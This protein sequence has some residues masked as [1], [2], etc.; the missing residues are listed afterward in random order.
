MPS[1][2]KSQQRLMGAAEHGAT[3][4]MAKKLR[5]SMSH[6]QLHDFAVG[7][8]K[9]KPE[10]THMSKDK[11]HHSPI[12]H[13]HV[14]HHSDGTKTVHHYHH[15]VSVPE[16]SA[17]M[18]DHSHAVAD[19]KGMQDNFASQMGASNEG[20]MPAATGAVPAQGE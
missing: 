15:P 14:V 7:S 8:E 19:L 6:S 9:H 17:E 5:E 12:K 4:P 18:G 1:V 10:H 13:S 3:F 16:V 2:S 11:K 20:G